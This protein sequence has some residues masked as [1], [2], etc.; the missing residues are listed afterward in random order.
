MGDAVGTVNE[1]KEYVFIAGPDHQGQG[2]DSLSRPLP[3]SVLVADSDCGKT[4][5]VVLCVSFM[6]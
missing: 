1:G 6:G 5:P 2:I 3:L 4:R